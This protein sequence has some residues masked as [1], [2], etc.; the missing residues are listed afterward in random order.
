FQGTT[1]PL[2]WNQFGGTFGGP[3]RRDKTFFFGSY[4]GFRV[5]TNTFVNGVLVPLVPQRTGDFSALAAAKRPIDP[6]PNQAFP[7]GIIPA[8]RLDPVAQNII[9]TLVPLPNTAAGTYSD[10]EPAPATEDQGMLRVDHQLTTSNRISG[11]LFIDRSNTTLPFGNN[12]NAQ[13]PN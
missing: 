6:T 8:S 11:T 1:N 4:Q 3:I 13:L 2:H 7:N 9:K 10:S 12:N 5:A